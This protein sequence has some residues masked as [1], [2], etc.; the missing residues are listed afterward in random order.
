M[1]KSPYS[2]MKSRLL[3]QSAGE[4]CRSIL[5]PLKADRFFTVGRQRLQG[6]PS[7]DRRMI[8]HPIVEQTS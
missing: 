7:G 3:W 2:R 6:S 1:C 8:Q 4:H 5:D